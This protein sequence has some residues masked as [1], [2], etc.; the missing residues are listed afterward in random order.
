MDEIRAMPDLFTCTQTHLALVSHACPIPVHAVRHATGMDMPHHVGEVVPHH[1][2][3]VI[4]GI[5]SD[6]LPH[7]EEPLPTW[8]GSQ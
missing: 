3:K 5:R 7:E 4:P 1:E 8:C 2:V 6:L